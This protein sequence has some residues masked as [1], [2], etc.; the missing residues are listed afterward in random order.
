MKVTSVTKATNVED[1]QIKGIPFA[2]EYE[3][4]TDQERSTIKFNDSKE[5][6]QTLYE[7][8]PSLTFQNLVDR[9]VTYYR[10]EMEKQ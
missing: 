5:I 3:S 2:K 9:F 8:L 10:I 4:L 1:W 6:F 7:N